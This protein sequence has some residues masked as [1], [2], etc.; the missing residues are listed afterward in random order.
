MFSKDISETS[1]LPYINKTY[2][3]LLDQATALSTQYQQAD[4]FP[5][6]YFENFFAPNF[7]SQVLDEFTSL[8]EKQQIREFNNKNE[9]KIGITHE[10]ALGPKTREMLHFLNSQPFLDFLE[11]LTGIE[12]L[13]PD[14]AFVGGGCHETLP[15]GYLKIHS[16][17]NKHG[18]TDLD[19]RLNILVYLNKDWK[20]EYGGHFELWDTEMKAQVKK[21]MPN[22]NTLAMFSTT[23]N[24][25]HGHPDPLNCPEGRSRKS[26]ALYYYTNGRPAEEI[27]KGKEKHSTLFK[28]RPSDPNEVLIKK[29]PTFV[30]KVLRKI[31]KTL[32]N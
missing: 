30:R 9:K 32:V 20:E 28:A 26:L 13:I 6:I 11:A 17:F 12:N 25:Y 15:G 18:A 29:N 3:E 10:L 14:P 8:K 16:D 7:L 22:F 2:T 19:R 4:P 23:S 24:S 21:V 1:L 27:I 5:N 31:K